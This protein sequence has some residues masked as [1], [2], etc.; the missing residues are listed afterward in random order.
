MLVTGSRTG[1]VEHPRLTDT[2]FRSLEVTRLLSRL[3]NG[4]RFWPLPAFPNAPHT[5]KRS[6]LVG[7]ER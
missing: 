7:P 3:E 1:E 5:W 6:G 2:P 4:N